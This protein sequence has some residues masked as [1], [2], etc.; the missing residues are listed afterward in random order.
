MNEDIAKNQAGKYYPFK[1]ACITKELKL[2]IPS[3]QDVWHE[4]K[5]VFTIGQPKIEASC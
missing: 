4:G 2:E 1:K 3:N 5:L